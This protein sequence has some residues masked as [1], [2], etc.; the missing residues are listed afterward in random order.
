MLAFLD[1]GNIGNA[2]IAGMAKD[3]ALDTNRYNWLLNMFYITYVIAE[4]SV[5]LWK[6][7]PPHIVGSF[8]VF[9]WS[10]F[11]PMSHTLSNLLSLLIS[12]LHFMLYLCFLSCLV[13]PGH[14]S[15]LPIS[16]T[17]MACTTQQGTDCRGASRCAELGGGEM[18]LRFLLGAFEAAYG[19]VV[20]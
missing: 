1:R 19:C 11:N 2:R 4:F 20:T 15:L 9:S 16:P 5:L 6:I 8:V 18:A 13:P 14:F 3:L 7:F 12:I 10:V 17:D